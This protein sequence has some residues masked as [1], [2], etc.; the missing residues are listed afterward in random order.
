MIIFAR[1]VTPNNPGYSKGESMSLFDEETKG[2]DG[3]EK[4]RLFETLDKE[5]EG[6]K[7]YWKFLVPIL[8]VVIAGIAV[9]VY[10]GSRRVGDSVRP[11]D[12]LYYAVNDNFLT[13]QKRTP[14]DLSFYYCGD[15]YSVD[16]MVEKKDVPPTKPEDT[17]TE[18]KATARKG[19]GG[20]Q[21]NA[22]AIGPKDKFIAC[23]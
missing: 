14:T 17:L 6:G 2:A 16:A 18:F 9:V 13:Q 21:V 8:V 23:K 7:N 1:E 11:D 5:D 3:V 4:N 19:D 10:F 15:Y 20:W 22:S 12:D